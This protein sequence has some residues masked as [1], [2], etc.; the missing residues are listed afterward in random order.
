MAVEMV[1]EI[2]RLEESVIPWVGVEVEVEAI[3]QAA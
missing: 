1:S 3:V 2:A